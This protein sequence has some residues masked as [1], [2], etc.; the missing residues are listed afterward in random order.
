M[1]EQSNKASQTVFQA[2]IKATERLLFG[3]IEFQITFEDIKEKVNSIS[4]WWTLL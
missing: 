3:V 2:M 4:I 1:P